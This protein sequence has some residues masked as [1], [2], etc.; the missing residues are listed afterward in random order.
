MM[1]PIYK[2]TV[3][4]EVCQ[5]KRFCSTQVQKSNSVLLRYDHTGCR[6]ESQFLSMNASQKNSELRNHTVIM[7]SS[8]I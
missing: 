7:V 3:I 6:T 4:R 2:A 1:L 8:R 5:R